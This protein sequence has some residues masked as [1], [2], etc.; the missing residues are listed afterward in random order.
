MS[1]VNNND[2]P[3]EKPIRNKQ[4]I[5][6]ENSLEFLEDKGG[7]IS[8]HTIPIYFIIVAIFVVACSFIKYPEILTSRAIIQASFSPKEILSRQDGRISKVFKSNDEFVKSGQVLAYIESIANPDE[9][10]KLKEKIDS[11]ILDIQQGNSYKLINRF[12]EDSQ[13]LGEIQSDYQNYFV[14]YKQFL[15][16]LQNGYYV[17]KRKALER[18]IALLKSSAAFLVEQEKLL[19]ADAKLA[20]TNFQSNQILLNERVISR[21][22]GRLELSKLIAKKLTIPQI[23]DQSISNRLQQNGKTKEIQDLEHSIEIQRSNFMLSL[24]TFSVIVSTWCQKFIISSPVDGKVSYIIPIDE[25]QFI[26][27][28]KIIGYVVPLSS[29]YFAEMT[30]PQFNFAKVKVNQIVNLRF[31][32]YP[33]PEYGIIKGKIVYISEFANDSGFL[34]RIKLPDLLLTDKSKLIRYRDGLSAEAKIVIKES[35][36]IEKFYYNI[37]GALRH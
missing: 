16:Y 30:L 33:F 37:I 29:E 5:S 19:E 17:S 14:A 35:L 18:D 25:N 12:S 20:D 2:H 34:T 15:D 13:K 22:E 31:N 8:R 6:N 7:F 26:K 36:L 21:Q 11:S 28:G 24:K 10:L 27:A 32:A 9:I 23:R 3:P 4:L 1:L